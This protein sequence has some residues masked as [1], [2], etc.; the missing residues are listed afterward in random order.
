MYYE[1][2]DTNVRLMGSMHAIPLGCGPLPPWV[3]TAYEWSEELYLE[4]DLAAPLAEIQRPERRTVRQKLSNRAWQA[5]NARWPGLRYQK[6]WFVLMG[7]PRLALTFEEGTGVESVLR[8]RNKTDG[9]ATHFLETLPEAVERF[10]VISDDV[11]AALLEKVIFDLDSLASTIR[12]MCGAWKSSNIRDLECLL[13]RLHL[14]QEP[15]I[16]RAFFETRNSAWMA[17]ILETLSTERR[18][19]I[20]AGAGHL[21]EPVGLLELLR[22]SGNQFRQL[23]S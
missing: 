20:I 12:D 6:L 10:D 15:I 23:S 21:C 9:K 3:G 2:E 7:M 1:I 8:N 11:Y 18:T 13:S 17:K 16:K 14:A 5:L 19:L 4:H 22:Q